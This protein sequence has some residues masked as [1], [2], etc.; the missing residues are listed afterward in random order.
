MMTGVPA[1]DVPQERSNF[2]ALVRAVLGG[3]H[4]AW[5]RLVQRVHPWLLRFCRRRGAGEDLCRDVSVRTIERLQARESWVLRRYVERS[6]AYGAPDDAGFLRWLAAVA[7]NVYIDTVRSQP[8]MV[9]S[10]TPEGRQMTQVFVDSLEEVGEPSGA[11]PCM[12]RAIDLSRIVAVLLE[13]D[14]P[15][16]QRQALRLWLLGHDAAEVAQKLALSDADEARR[17]LHAARQRLRRRVLAKVPSR[18]FGAS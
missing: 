10:Q 14:F 12:A 15:A 1:T 13:Q 17:L 5:Q 18:S 8:E 7:N 16:K 2:T 3:E 6:R 4:H 11:Q 9:R